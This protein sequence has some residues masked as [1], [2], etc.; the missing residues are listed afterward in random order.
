MCNRV[1]PHVK[2]KIPAMQSKVVELKLQHELPPDSQVWLIPENTSKI[3][4][5]QH[6]VNTILSSGRVRTIVSNPTNKQ[7]T[8]TKFT[9]I[10]HVIS[11]IQVQNIPFE[12]SNSVNND[13][14][15][16]KQTTDDVILPPFSQNQ[17]KQTDIFPH[18]CADGEHSRPTSPQGAGTFNEDPREKNQNSTYNFGRTSRHQMLSS[19]LNSGACGDSDQQLA[20]EHQGIF[21]VVGARSSTSCHNQRSQ[22]LLDNSCPLAS[23][24][25]KENDNKNIKEVHALRKQELKPEY[26][27][28][29]HLDR[30]TRDIIL[31]LLMQNYEVFSTSYKTLGHT[32]AVQPRTNLLHS[33]PIAQKAFPINN[34]ML[35]SQ[36]KEIKDLLEAGIIERSKSNYAFPLI[37]VKKKQTADQ[38]KNNETAFRCVVDYRLLNAITEFYPFNLPKIQDIL[39]RQAGKK[40]YTILDFKA[41][42]MQVALPPEERDKFTLIT[43]TQGKF[44]PNRLVFGFINSST[45]FSEL[46][47]L[48]FGDLTDQSIDH[49]LDDLIISA[50]SVSEMITKLKIV[51]ERLKKFNLTLDPKKSQILTSEATFLGFKVSKAGISPSDHNINK[52]TSF[53][54][55]KNAKNVRCFLGL[56]NYFRNILPNYAQ[57]VKPLT[58][59]TRKGIKFHWSQECKQTFEYLQYLLLHKPIIT[60]PDSTKPFYLACDASKDCIAAILMQKDNDGELHP[61]FYHSRKLRGAETHYDILKKE[62]LALYDSIKSFSQFLYGTKFYVL[63]DCR[64]LTFHLNLAKQPEI[65]RRWIIELQEFN[66]EMKFIPGS[67]NPADYFS[68]ENFNTNIIPQTVNQ[69]FQVNKELSL[70]NIS[71]NQQL[72]AF[73]LKIRSK[74]QKGDK[75]IQNNYFVDEKSDLL[76]RNSQVK[77][78]NKNDK[79]QPRVVVP[80]NLIKILISEA[81]FTHFGPDKTYGIIAKEYYW[82]GM[83]R[84]VENYC[85]RCEKC[86]IFKNKRTMQEPIQLIDKGQNAH[87]FLSIDIVGP[88]I[89]SI[90]GHKYIL[91]ILCMFS[92]FLISIPLRNTSTLNIIQELTTIFC[93][94]GIPKTLLSDNASYFKGEVFQN[95]MDTLGINHRF[96]SIYRPNSNGNLES[97]HG[98]LKSSLACMASE[99]NDWNVRI[100]YFTLYYNNTLNRNTKFTP[101]ELFWGKIQRLPTTFN[102]LEGKKEIISVSNFV[103]STKKHIQEMAAIT[104][105]IQQRIFEQEQGKK[106]LKRRSRKFEIG[107]QVFLKNLIYKGSLRPKTSGP[108]F[109]TRKFR[110]SNYLIQFHDN[111]EKPIKMHS[112]K[113][114][115]FPSIRK[116]LI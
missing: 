28:L 12:N 116:N 72:D 87:E 7:I 74:L 58:D 85:N 30:Q 46:M 13:S 40:Y 99:A 62:L 60:S 16:G 83:F 68:R 80:V 22:F 82:P 37:M 90:N 43:N 96:T 15:K 54:T 103:R 53:P 84:D 92:R 35:S 57:L 18:A 98:L 39:H 91:T 66:F 45:I 17:N 63:T 86:V 52:I 105:Q 51:F 2:V 94:Y 102:N 76:F 24:N 4:N 55:P 101:S 56:L 31:K 36:Q 42:F 100:N 67:S 38:K 21:N 104:T 27:D 93:R 75:N 70:Q 64:A 48:V 14:Q 29:N 19:S 50:D 109:I 114:I 1:T 6:S 89:R 44:R 65:A 47:Q 20:G 59:L 10:A 69:I 9:K 73:C 41:A 3:F 115:A 23:C 34:S 49:F 108:Y 25:D 26:F 61:V 111:S 112:D 78:T 33:Y 97:R 107:D 106:N 77:T 8:L 95:F 81:H 88:L 11:E 32:N 113:L 110:N 79:N 71:C 5:V